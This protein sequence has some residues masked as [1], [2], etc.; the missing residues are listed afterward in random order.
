MQQGD[1][2]T[3]REQRR[4]ELLHRIFSRV[5][6][7]PLTNEGKFRKARQ[8]G[9]WRILSSIE[10]FERLYPKW[11]KSPCPKTLLRRWSNGQTTQIYTLPFS[12]TEFAAM[13]KL[14]VH[15]ACKL[16]ELPIS[17]STI[18]RRNSK[19]RFAGKIA[20]IERER[21]RLANAVKNLLQDIKGIEL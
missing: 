9:A 8:L 3:K 21:K 2:S 20:M 19:A 17:Y 1:S 10:T 12:V 5:H 6:G 16:F 11:K 18:L 15:A 14:S 13:K 4:A 7:L